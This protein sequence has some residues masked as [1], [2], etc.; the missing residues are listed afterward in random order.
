MTY[1][2]GSYTGCLF[3][4]GELT[5]WWHFN[6]CFGWAGLIAEFEQTFTGKR[7]AQEKKELAE[8]WSPYFNSIQGSI[9][10]GGYP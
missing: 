8:W 7:A 2:C 10:M 1:L 9:Y 5:G 6:I 3:V 4:I